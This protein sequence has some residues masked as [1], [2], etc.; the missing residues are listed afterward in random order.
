VDWTA[1]TITRKRSKTDD[2]ED[3]PEVTWKLW[4]I[5][6]ELLKKHRSK[7]PTLALTARS[8]KPLV[9][10]RLKPDG[11]L[12]K[13]DKIMSNYRRLCA[14]TGID[15]PPKCIRKTSANLLESHR[16]YA[17]FAGYFLGPAEKGVK[18]RHYTDMPHDL[19]FEALDWLRRQYGF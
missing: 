14:E 16:D 17:R 2:R 12:T 18:A 19:F 11:K 7:H 10:K 9:E 15:K 1:G 3:T 5:T 4:P 6:F 13:T 8:G